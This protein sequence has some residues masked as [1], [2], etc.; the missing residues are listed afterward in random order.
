MGAR[1]GVSAVSALTRAGAKAAISVPSAPKP[2]NVTQL[3]LVSPKSLQAKFKHAADFGISGNYSI[4]N[5]AKFN[6]AIVLHLNSPNTRV[7]KGTYRGQSVVHHFNPAT[8]LNVVSQ[9]GRFVSGWKLN[10]QQRIY[11]LRNGSL[12]GG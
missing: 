6:S 5:A 4:A 3:L 8:G 11:L 9:G 7:I 12:G 10:S 1:G 2:R